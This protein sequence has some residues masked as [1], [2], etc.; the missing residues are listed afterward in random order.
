MIVYT[1]IFYCAELQ[2]AFKGK[3]TRK[4]ADTLHKCAMFERQKV[5]GR[6]KLHLIVCECD[7]I[8]AFWP[9]VKEWAVC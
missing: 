4:V 6:I 5:I 3:L 8:H 2:L 7:M 9:I 1:P